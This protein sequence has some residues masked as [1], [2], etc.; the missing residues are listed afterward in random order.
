MAGRTR[1]EGFEIKPFERDKENCSYCTLAPA[2]IAYRPG[3]DCALDDTDTGVYWPA[4][5]Q[6]GKIDDL[7]SAIQQILQMQAQRVNDLVEKKF[8]DGTD[9]KVIAKHEERVDRNLQRLFS[10]AM[11]YR[12]AK[13]PRP[14]PATRGR[15]I[16]QHGDP[17]LPSAPTPQLMAEALADLEQ[18]G[19]NRATLTRRDA[20]EHLA[21][22]GLI[23]LPAGGDEELI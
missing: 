16:N 3:E 8:D 9:P 20:I 2:C 19:F 14:A 22:K 13:T 5:F 4:Q 17:D 6:T 21:G 18:M 1:N 10:N 12:T 7:D 23:A 15:I 11:Q